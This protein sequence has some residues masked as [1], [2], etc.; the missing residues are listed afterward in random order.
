MPE[1]QTWMKATACD[2]IRYAFPCG[3]G[4]A[5]ILCALFWRFCPGSR[6]LSDSV[7]P[8]ESGSSASDRPD[9]VERWGG[10]GRDGSVAVCIDADGNDVWGNLTGGHSDLN[11]ISLFWDRRGDD[12]YKR[13][14]PFDPA[15]IGNRPFGSASPYP[16]MRNFRDRLL[17]AGVFL[18][19]GGIDVY[20]QGMT[21]AEN[22][23]WQLQSDPM[24]WRWG[25]D[26]NLVP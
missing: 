24:V 8:G 12:I 20:P 22:T 15:M 9:A 25:L 16:P 13:I 3:S 11:S 4:R 2:R 10:L 21:A 18:D 17:S 26:E 14:Q 5:D 23:E 6:W 19:T 7:W 1:K